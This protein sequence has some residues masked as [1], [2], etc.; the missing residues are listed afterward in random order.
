MKFRLTDDI[1]QPTQS[2]FSMRRVYF[3]PFYHKIIRRQHFLS[4]ASLHFNWLLAG[5]P[6]D[7]ET[8]KTIRCM[9]TNTPVENSYIVLIRRFYRSIFL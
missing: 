2:N 1:I 5:Q 7:R 3:H 6:W 9:L 4:N 8:L